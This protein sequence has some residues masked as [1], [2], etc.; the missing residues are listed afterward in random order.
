M[1]SVA[2]T[3]GHVIIGVDQATLHHVRSH[4]H[5]RVRQY[6]R[7][8]LFFPLYLGSS[9]LALVRGGAP[10]RGNVF[11]R[12]AFA[13]AGG[14]E[15]AARG[16]RDDAKL[17]HLSLVCS[18]GVGGPAHNPLRRNVEGGAIASIMPVYGMKQPCAAKRRRTCSPKRRR[19]PIG[20]IANA[21]R[22]NEALR[23]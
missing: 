20:G 9:M 14:V 15:R 4:E 6:E 8:G 5:V 19:R 17:L 22:A 21:R 2:I 23:E 3:L 12:Q 13:S 7:W 11:E 10:Y 1:R 16:P 18:R